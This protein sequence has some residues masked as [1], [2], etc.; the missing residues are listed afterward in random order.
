MSD[1]PIT[2]PTASPIVLEP[3]SEP[4]NGGKGD[5][6]WVSVAAATRSILRAGHSVTI[7][8]SHTRRSQWTTSGKGITDLP[9]PT[10][11]LFCWVKTIAVRSVNSLSTSQIVRHSTSIMFTEVALFAVFYANSATVVSAC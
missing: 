3:F 4:P 1:G 9:P 11:R 6:T 2:T 5:T 10:S 7:A 8:A